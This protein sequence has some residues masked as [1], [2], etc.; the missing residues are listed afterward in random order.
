MRLTSTR[1]EPRYCSTRPEHYR[2][3]NVRPARG[4]RPRFRVMDEFG[5]YCQLLSL[6]APPLEAMAGPEKS[7]AMA[8]VANDAL[9]D[10][11]AK[12][13]HRFIGFVASLPLNNPEESVKEMN[14]AVFE[15]GAQG[16][17]IFSNVAGKPLDAPEFRPLFEE[18]ARRDVVIWLHPARGANFPDYLTED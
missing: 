15:L 5:E 13:P 10:L 1:M 9:A 7:P 2:N 6:P 12:H 18:A 3:N 8:K 17:Q 11:F 4:R 14:R 16:I